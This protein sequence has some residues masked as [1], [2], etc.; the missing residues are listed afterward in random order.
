VDR[1]A[2]NL[3]QQLK[4]AGLS[5]RA[6]NAAWPTWWSDRAETSASA[7]A[8]LRF[9]LARNLGLSPKSLLGERVEFVW[10][11][12]ARFKH[13]GAETEEQ[14]AALTSFG[15]SVGRPIIRG[16]RPSGDGLV[17]VTAL[18]L[19]S[20]VLRSRPFVDLNALLALC[21]GL[22]VPVVHLR[23]FPL[24]AKGMHATVIKEESRH[25][26]L[27]CR[28]AK[29]PAPVAFTLAHEIGH[30]ALGHLGNAAAL[31][32]VTDPA[33]A[34]DKDDEEQAA[35]EF[36]LS[37]L[38]GS[39]EPLIQT[40]TERYGA[41]QLA[42]AVLETAPLKRIEP[43]TLALCLAYRSSRW[44]TAMASL[45]H[46]YTEHKPVWREVNRIAQRQVD[47]ETLGAESSDFLRNV[48]GL[49]DD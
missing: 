13:L 40:N 24:A 47:W 6:I 26:I 25:A 2:T 17:G 10:R 34:T 27:L 7:N 8:E 43:G 15:V 23:V 42:D 31:V 49:A 39:P 22:G 1:N 38:T 37:L 19:R 16:T 9:T 20:A 4:Q 18:A 46:I 33:V 36:A 28:D 32:D 30:V 21:W 11:N 3:R 14:K 48:L 35:D 5:D 29:Y 12:R 41:K 44:P 45:R